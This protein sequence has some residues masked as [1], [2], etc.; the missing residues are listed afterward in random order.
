MRIAFFSVSDQ[1]GGS[2][3]VLLLILRELRRRRPSWD[4]HVILPGTGPLAAQAAALGATVRTLPMPASLARL[5]EWGLRGRA[6]PSTVVR[7]LRAALGLLP[8]ERA[9]GRALAAIAPDV[10]HSNGFKAH[11]VAARAGGARQGLI[12][13]MH[14]YVSTRPLT[15]VLIRRYAGRARLI[16]ANSESVA[17]DV[18]RITGTGERLRVIHNGVDLDR[19]APVGP[20]ADLD[21]L[22]GLA[23]APEGTVRVGLVATFSRWKGHA[24]FLRAIAQLPRSCGIRAYVVGNAVYDTAGSQHTMADLQA[25]A[26]QL[27]VGDRVGF[28]GFVPAAEEVLRALDIVIHAST[29][30]EP[31]GLVIAE[32]MACG[33]ALVTSGAGG[34]GELVR[35]GEDALIHRPGDAID[36]ASAIERLAA[37]PALRSRLGR[38]ARA[39][40]VR[41]FDARRFGDDFASA[42]EAAATGAPGRPA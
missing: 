6:L 14:E 9:F 17:E 30:P 1:L 11:I 32:A 24:A 41:R 12:W 16:V 36:L 19:F 13:H 23:P 15:R 40:A 37:N 31:F 28:T 34:A 39:T 25:L 22:S 5:G 20:V 35:E 10:V 26:G 18:R 21:A 4:L 2:E 33:R 27:G 7:L 38:A 3:V 8:Y 42:C 29:I